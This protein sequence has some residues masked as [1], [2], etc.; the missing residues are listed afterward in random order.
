[1]KKTLLFL[2][3]L[4]SC[5]LVSRGQS[6]CSE[7]VTAISG[8]NSVP[9][10]SDDYYWY[11]YTM[12]SDG[13]LQLTSNTSQFVAVYKN[14]NTLFSEGSGSGNTSIT[15]LSSGDEVFIRWNTLNET[16][17]SWNLSV[18]PLETGD[19]CEL[20]ATAT[21]GT[22]ALPTTFANYYWYR[23]T[24]PIDG[25]LQISSET[26]QYIAVF[27]TCEN[28]SYEGGGNGK[29]TI[30]ALSSGDEVFI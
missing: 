15:T 24:M 19:E 12:P 23:Y 20:A 13:K 27:S 2:C 3:T 14:C 5:A 28:Y 7:A 26:S 29:A 11:H 8:A 16:A 25:K 21:S 1:M 22:N 4:L 9:A 30:T 18:L 17:F 10:T 6:T